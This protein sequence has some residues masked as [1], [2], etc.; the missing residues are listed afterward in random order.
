MPSTYEPISTQTLASAAAT[1]T[2][3]SIPST[4]TDLILVSSCTNSANSESTLQVNGDSGS[5]YSTV[6]L[7]GNGSAV[8]AYRYNTTSIFT[9]VEGC[10]TGQYN[11]IYNFQNYA[12]TST[13][14]TILTRFNAAAK[15][16]SLCIGSWRT[17]SAITS[18]TLGNLSGG[19]FN[20]GSIF[21]LYGIKA[22]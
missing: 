5:N 10:G 14:K 16:T 4:Y 7:S 2:F 17:T 3:S 12:N 6:L 22:A 11:M 1:V 21:T 19:N 13:Y 9:Q 15:G 18:I 8:A 20:T